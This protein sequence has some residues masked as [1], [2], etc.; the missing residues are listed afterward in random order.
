MFSAKLYLVIVWLMQLP[1]ICSLSVA[2]EIYPLWSVEKLA[3]NLA[4]CFGNELIFK[5]Y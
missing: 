2:V 4:N 1:C 3:S 5:A